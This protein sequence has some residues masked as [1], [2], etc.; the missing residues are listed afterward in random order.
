MGESCS[1]E[2]KRMIEMGGWGQRWDWKNVEKVD[3]EC[4]DM[5]MR[6]PRS[7]RGL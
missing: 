2:K 1:S 7:I 5:D 4:V 3:Y 6:D